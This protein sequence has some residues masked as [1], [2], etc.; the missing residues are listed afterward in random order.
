MSYAVPV[1]WTAPEAYL[2]R[3]YT[4]KS[5]VWSYGV[6]LFEIFSLGQVPYSDIES[7]ID[8]MDRVKQGH[9]LHQPPHAPHAIYKLMLETWNENPKLRPNFADVVDQFEIME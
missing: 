1:R 9:R 6:L 8:V 7:N 2:Q 3:Q 4:N 5:D